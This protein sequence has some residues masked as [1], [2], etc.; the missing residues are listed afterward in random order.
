MVFAADNSDSPNE[1]SS[2]SQLEIIRGLVKPTATAVI[3]SETSARIKKLPYKSGD[4][5]KKGDEL[6]KFDCGLYYAQ[7]ASAK[8]SLEGKQKSLE[9]LKRLL[10]LNATSDVEV[11]LAEIEVKKSKADLSV[12][13]ITVSRCSIKAPYDG[14]VIDTVVNRHENISEG[15]ELLSI[16]NDKLLEIEVIVPSKWLVWMEKGLM[17]EFHVDEIQKT[18]LAK[19]VQIGA[20]VDPVSQTVSIKG[21]F[22]EQVDVLAGMSGSARFNLDQ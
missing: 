19:V 16:L 3:S 7:L 5:F 21:A 2:D 4:S 13:S 12:S 14:R 18:Y 11:E 10:A 1:N 15:Q 17:F 8:A 20:I 9:N 6:I 22:T